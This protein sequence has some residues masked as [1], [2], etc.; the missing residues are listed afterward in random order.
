MPEFPRKVLLDR[1]MVGE[2]SVREDAVIGWSWRAGVARFRSEGDRGLFATH[3]K[4]LTNSILKDA[5]PESCLCKKHLENCSRWTLAGRRH[6]FER[7]TTI[8]VSLHSL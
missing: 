7:P 1:A 4:N 5:I 8:F 6:V 3:V 2:A